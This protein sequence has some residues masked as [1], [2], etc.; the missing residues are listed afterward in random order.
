MPMGACRKV[1]VK[2]KLQV[3]EFQY[4]NFPQGSRNLMRGDGF[5]RP[6]IGAVLNKVPPDSGYAYGGMGCGTAQ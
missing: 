5:K 1:E 3:N 2:L 6:A 4:Q